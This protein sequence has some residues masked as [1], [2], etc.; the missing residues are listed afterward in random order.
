MKIG[1][2]GTGT[3]V[4]TMLENLKHFP[5]F[6]C[7]AVY[8]RREATALNFARRFQVS[9]TYTDLDAMCQDPDIDCIYIASPNSLHY[10]QARKALSYGKHVLCEKP[11]T[12]HLSEAREL[13]RLAGEKNLLLLETI[14]TVYHPNFAKVA[15]L[16]PEIGDIQMIQGTFCQ[17]S[18][19]Y[20]AFLGGALPNVFNPDFAGG[21]LMDINLYNIYFVAALLGKPHKLQYLAAK[22]F[23][24]IDTHGILSMEYPGILCTLTGAKDCSAEN[25]I[26]IIGTNGY[27]HI[28][29]SASFCQ[30]LRLVCRN[31]PEQTYSK[32][33]AI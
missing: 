9:K 18:G 33:S 21:A 8:S 31:R 29:P 32:T 3:I 2:V 14:T 30:H 23:N 7:E 25:G 20:D 16:L 1:T 24:G 22:A 10:T 17:Y 13:V 11:F 12:V 26:Q 6:S 27:M 4:A 15:E 19:K 5:D 28:T